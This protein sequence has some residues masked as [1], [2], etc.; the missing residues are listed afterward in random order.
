MITI[1]SYISAKYVNDAHTI[2]DVETDTVEH[3]IIPITVDI[4]NPDTLEH[5]QKIIT[6]LPNLTIAP[7]S[8][9]VSEASENK[10]IE[11][12]LAMDSALSTGY[13]CTNGITM[14][15][16][17]AHVTMLDEGYRLATRLGSS[18]MDIRDKNN[19]RHMA[20]PI[21]DVDAMIN[22]LGTN[23]LTQWTKKCTLQEQVDAIVADTNKTDTQKVSEITAIVW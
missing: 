23:W 3:G 14:Q 16:E 7:F 19:V 21:A 13:T 5:I 11:I 20:T 8:I 6:D 2:V 15:A 4:V 9:T 12:T 1:K 18:T 10:K 22:E 17:R